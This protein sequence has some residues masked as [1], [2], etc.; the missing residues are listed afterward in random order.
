MDEETSGS[1]F[2]TMPSMKILHIFLIT[3]GANRRTQQAEGNG[4]SQQFSQDTHTQ[5]FQ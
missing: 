5:N 2:V 4:T 1:Y 3:V